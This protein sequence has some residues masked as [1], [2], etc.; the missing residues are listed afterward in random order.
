MKR[1]LC[2]F[3]ALCL[4]FGL[5]A[6]HSA[7]TP[8]E[9]STASASAPTS[10]STT[11]A[12]TEPST[13][14]TT[15]ASTEIPT[16]AAPQSDF[17][18]GACTVETYRDENGTIWAMGIAEIVNKSDT[19]LYLDYGTFAFRGGDDTLVMTADAIAAYPQVLMP[20]ESG[21]YFEVVEPD[22]PDTEPLQ[23]TV[24][25]DIRKAEVESV[26][27]TVTDTQL[28]NSPYG[29]LELFGKVENTTDADGELV[30]IAA[31]LLDAEGKPIGLLTT[32]LT[33]K[34]N[35]GSTAEFT[36]E[37]FMLPSELKASTAAQTLCFAYPLQE[38]P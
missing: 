36:L 16:T 32:I 18:L 11:Q 21:Y 7:P 30:C 38:Q 24:T 10:E 20:G 33:E 14:P 6:C 25:P 17:E 34:L 35:A 2:L 4:L 3:C 9:S 1:L 27:Y 12:R 8:T 37:S 5:C 22:L 13:E 31:V 29:G 15:E 19:P 28:R 26:R 23:L